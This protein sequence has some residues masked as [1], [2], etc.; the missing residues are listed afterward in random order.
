MQR[1]PKREEN[2]RQKLMTFLNKSEFTK[3]AYSLIMEMKQ[4]HKCW[5]CTDERKHASCRS[6]CSNVIY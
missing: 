2:S 4:K 1:P 6:F 3:I 5:I